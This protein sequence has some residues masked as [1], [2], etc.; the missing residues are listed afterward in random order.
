MQKAELSGA[1]KLVV[2]ME[3]VLS[4]QE[5]N[6]RPMLDTLLEVYTIRDMLLSTCATLS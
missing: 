2:T 5:L 6:L 1:D 4:C 3:G